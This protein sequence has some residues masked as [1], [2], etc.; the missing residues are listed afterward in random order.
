MHAGC[1]DFVETPFID[2]TMMSKMEHALELS[3]QKH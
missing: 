1:I 3:Q 2:R